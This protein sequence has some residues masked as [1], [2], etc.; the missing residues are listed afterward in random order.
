MKDVQTVWETLSFYHRQR[1]T[2]M[3]GGFSVGPTQI[4]PTG[5]DGLTQEGKG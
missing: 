1:L 4:M 2:V 3:M 5:T